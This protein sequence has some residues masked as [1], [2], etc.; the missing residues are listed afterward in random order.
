[1]LIHARVVHTCRELSQDAQAVF[2]VFSYIL[3]RNIRTLMRLA[4]LPDVLQD[5]YMGGLLNGSGYASSSL[6]VKHTLSDSIAEDVVEELV[7]HL[8]HLD[9]TLNG[10]FWVVTDMVLE[11]YQTQPHSEL[12]VLD[13]LLVLSQPLRSIGTVVA[14]SPC[15]YPAI[16]S[17]LMFMC[18]AEEDVSFA[19]LPAGR[20][21]ACFCTRPFRATSLHPQRRARSSISRRKR[22]D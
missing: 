7:L 2:K 13:E 19:C 3:E 15:R 9:V 22:C 10:G 17:L 5:S 14:W 16:Y 20:R 11:L 21:L 12:L 6:N 18:A 8:Q 1:M 4:S